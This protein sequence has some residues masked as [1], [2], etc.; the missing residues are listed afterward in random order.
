MHPRVRKTVTTAVV[1]YTPYG[2]CGEQSS[3]VAGS[4]TNTSVFSCQCRFTNVSR[5]CFIHIPSTLC[6]FSSDSTPQD[7]FQLDCSF[8]LDISETTFEIYTMKF[9][10]VDDSFYCYCSNNSFS[11]LDCFTT[12][13]FHIPA[14]TKIFFCAHIPDC[15]CVAFF[16]IWY[17]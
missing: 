9:T 6:N 4:C 15:H 17:C 2:I 7:A 1:Y 11:Y 3:T 12:S 10:A 13:V 5:S 14:C 16:K 8:R